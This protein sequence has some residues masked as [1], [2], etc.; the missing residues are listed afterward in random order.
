M[1][2]ERSPMQSF[3]TLVK[4]W[5]ILCVVTFSG[6]FAGIKLDMPYTEKTSH[7]ATLELA[8]SSMQQCGKAK[9]CEEFMGRFKLE[10][11]GKMYDREIDGFFYHSFVDK[12]RKPM[13]AYLTL[14]KN[15]KGIESPG[16]IKFLLFLGAI[17]GFL[18]LAGGICLL[19]GG[20]DVE[21]E[22]KRWTEQKE[23]EERDARWNAKW[24]NM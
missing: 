5:A 24:R 21:Y 3:M 2:N 22:Q 13:P 6:C 23:Q 14:N 10:E 12:G 1:S 4:V 7:N 8:Y 9:S 15:D 16:Y 17:G 20:T 18:F 19:I 11:D